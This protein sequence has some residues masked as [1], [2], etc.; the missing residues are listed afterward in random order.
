MSFQTRMTFFFY[1]I[2]KMN[3]WR[4]DQAPPLKITKVNE[5]QHDK[6]LKWSIQFVH[7]IQSLK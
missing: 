7:Y 1:G 5:D 6:K 3:F 2:Q 4:L